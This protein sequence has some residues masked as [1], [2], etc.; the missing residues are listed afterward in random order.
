MNSDE[1]DTRGDEQVLVGEASATPGEEQ[2]E[3]SQDEAPA[4]GEDMSEDCQPKVV[5]VDPGRPSQAE[6]DEHCIDHLPYRSWCDC[7]VRGRGTGEQH[8]PAGTSTIPVI[9]FD[10]LFITREKILLREEL[11]DEEEKNAVLKVLVV[12]DTKSRTIFAHAVFQKGP[13]KRVT[14]EPE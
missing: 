13:T 7:C 10:Y 1:T 12:K 6:I 5:S 2:P 3:A 14:R 4:E 9:A 8:R 11:T